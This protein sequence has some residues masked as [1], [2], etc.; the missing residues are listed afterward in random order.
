MKTTLIITTLFGLLGMAVTGFAAEVI[1]AD[2]LEPSIN[3]AVSAS[4]L[5]FTQAE[6]DKVAGSRKGG[7]A[8]GTETS[9]DC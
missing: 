8:T 9:S 1:D 7:A 3:G 2:A 6:E 4:G 5:Y